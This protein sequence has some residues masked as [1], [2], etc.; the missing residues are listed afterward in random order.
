MDN[1]CGDRHL[2]RE[3]KGFQSCMLR[4][5]LENIT[6]LG[7]LCRRSNVQQEQQSSPVKQGKNNGI[8]RMAI[9]V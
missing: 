6:L 9:Q 3:E 5:V 8:A 2:K 7:R 4:R 1:L